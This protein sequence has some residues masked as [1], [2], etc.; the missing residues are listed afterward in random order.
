MNL[1]ENEALFE[2]MVF[3]DFYVF[4]MLTHPLNRI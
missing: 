1:L 3:Y 4:Q 2:K